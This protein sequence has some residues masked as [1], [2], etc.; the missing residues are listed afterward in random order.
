MKRLTSERAMFPFWENRIKTLVKQERGAEACKHLVDAQESL[1]P[2]SSTI[3]WTPFMRTLC[4]EIHMM[5]MVAV[6]EGSEAD[7][8]IQG[9]TDQNGFESWRL[10][11]QRYDPI[12]ESTKTKELD[13]VLDPPKAKS[14]GEIPRLIDAWESKCS[15]LSAENKAVNLRQ[16]R[17]DVEVVT[18]NL[19][20]HEQ[21]LRQEPLRM[22]ATELRAQKQKLQE[23]LSVLDQEAKESM[24]SIPEQRWEILRR[25]EV[26][27]ERSSF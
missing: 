23:R 21:R 26:F 7:S 6:A 2:R 12:T 25:V 5:L 22:R 13:E 18:Q 11:K 1:L 20:L 24:L 14:L 17:H 3:N 8:L 15:R 4:P 9:V 10:V 27:L 19:N 16:L